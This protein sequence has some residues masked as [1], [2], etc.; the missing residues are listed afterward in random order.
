M[1]VF[2]DTPVAEAARVMA[3][4]GQDRLVVVASAGRVVGMVSSVDLFRAPL[5]LPAERAD[6]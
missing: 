2:L 1:S 4:R 6:A 5:G 3:E